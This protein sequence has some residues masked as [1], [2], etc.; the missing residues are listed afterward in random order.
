M[1]YKN[2]LQTL[3]HVHT[4]LK[5]QGLCIKITMLVLFILKQLTIQKY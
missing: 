4:F 1:C 5:V 3:Q 2:G